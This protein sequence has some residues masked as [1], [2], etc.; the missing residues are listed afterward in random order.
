MVTHL[1]TP[2]DGVLRL[3]SRGTHVLRVQHRLNELARSG[4][5]ADGAFGLRTLRA[6]RAWQVQQRFVADGRVDQRT[7][8][9]LGFSRY[10]QRQSYRAAQPEAHA[11][12]PLPHLP[13]GPL[14]DLVLSAIQTVNLIFSTVARVMAPLESMVG[15]AWGEVQR[16]RSTARARALQNLEQLARWANPKVEA[17]EATMRRIARMLGT[18]IS[19]ALAWIGRA[20][21]PLAPVMAKLSARLATSLAQIWRVIGAVLNGVGGW[22]QQIL[23]TAER[24]MRQLTLALPEAPAPG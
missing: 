1:D 5:H 2:L 9:S 17:V 22:A 18:A 16:A 6:V 14:R 11:V 3:G 8:E 24:V 12:R 4:L 23:A 15:T 21:A 7:A 19:T 10:V 20:S 13:G